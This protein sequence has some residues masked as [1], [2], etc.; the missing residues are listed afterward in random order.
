MK[1]SYILFILLMLAAFNN[2]FAQTVY[3][4][5]A[6]SSYPANCTNCTFN[7]TSG[8]TLSISQGGSCNNCTF[9]GGNIVLEKT[10]TCQPCSFNNTTIAMNDQSINTNSGTTS[11]Q[12][13]V[14]TATGSASIKA[15]T[16]INISNSVFTFNGT[17]YFS[18]NGGQLDISGSTLNFFGN[19]YFNANA[20]PVNLRNGSKLVAGN[21]LLNSLAYIKLNGPALNIYDNT[22]SVI[23]ANYN[24]Y[25]YNWNSFNSLS[26]NHSYTTTYPSAAS[27]LNCGAAGQN[28][29]GLYSAPT[30]YGPSGLTYAGVAA[31]SSLL[32]VVMSNFTVANTGS[33]V[34]LEWTT[35][36]EIN[37]AYFTIERSANS[38]NWEKIGAV[39]ATGNTAFATRYTYADNGFPGTVAYY[40]LAMVDQDGSKTYSTIKAVHASL[41][42]GISVFP[43]PAVDNVTV[44]LTG[45][46]TEVMIK[47][48]NQ[49]G[50][51]LQEQKAGANT[52]MV[53]LSVQQ[54]ARGT[55]IIAVSAADGIQQTSKLMIAR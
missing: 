4:V 39:P 42:K 32:P 23:L 50:Q 18:N 49:S 6:N 27:T 35:Q 16:A 29:C 21:G 36:Q 31:S 34:S 19:T 55:Y 33:R 37:A 53:S 44:D 13:V 25:Y 54:Y 11:F 3:A 7:I 45:N 24:N 52:A 10:I 48:M 20:G 43:N 14:L 30:V 22:S 47:L 51:V 40:R 5:T 26:N 17:G 2:S 41:I 8:K 28:A 9:N 1:K 46:S 12:N 15:N 38:S